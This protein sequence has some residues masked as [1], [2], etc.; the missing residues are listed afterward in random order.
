[1][2]R[3]RFT[4]K[5]DLTARNRS[6]L[7]GATVEEMTAVPVRRIA[8]A[9]LVPGGD[10]RPFPDPDKLLPMHA[11]LGDK[12]FNS[13]DWMWEPK[14]DGYRAL[15]FID[16]DGVKLRSRRGL[17]LGADFPK[18]VAELGRQSVDGMVLDGEIVAFDAS[19]KASFGAMQNRG[20]GPERAVF[21]CFD[22]LYFAGVDV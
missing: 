14:L 4:A 7:S 18:L 6:V 16:G 1:K 11:E 20:S 12:A 13:A 10:K 9:Q 19:G 5:T 2:H 17:E 3:D 21:Y 8:A 22:L 15:A